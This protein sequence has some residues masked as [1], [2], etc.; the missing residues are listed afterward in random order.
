MLF[1]SGI[2]RERSYFVGNNPAIGIRVDRSQ[3]G[4]AID[5]QHTVET[6]SKKFEQ[7]LPLGT[8]VDLIRTRADY[9]AGRL[10]MLL[11]NGLTG[12][13]LVVLLLFLFLNART[14]FWVA[15]GIP[16]AMLAAITVMYFAGIT[17]NMISLFALIITLGIVVDD[18]I[19]VGEH[20][21][22]R[23]RMG[24]E[25]Y[26][27]AESA[28]KRMALPVFAATLTTIIAFFGLVVIGGRFGDLIADIPFTVVAVLAAS[29]VECFLILPNHM[30]H[31]LKHVGNNYWYDWPSRIVNFGFGWFREKIFGPFTR[32]VISSRYVV[33]AGAIAILASQVT[34]VISGKVN[35]RFF[36]APEQSSVTGNFAMVDTATREDTLAM[37]KTLQKTVEDLAKE[38][39]EKHGKNPVKYLLAEVGGNSGRGLSGTENKSKD[40]LGGIGIELIDADLRPYSSFAFVGELRDRVPRTALLEQISFRG[41]RAGPGGDALDIQLFGSSSKVLKEA[42]EDLKNE[43]SK[44]SQVSALED[45]LAYDKDDLILQLTP[46]GQAI[47]FTID[48]LGAILRSRLN[49]IEA[50][51]YPVGPRSA[52]ISVKL[53]EGELTSDFLDRMLL[54]APDGSY[55]PLADL[56]SVDR[57][58]GFSTVRR[59][60]GIRIV[61][62]TGDVSEDDPKAAQQV[63]ETLE[64]EIL[65]DLASK[66]QIEWQLAGL[67][68]QEDRFL[69]EARIGLITCLIGIYLVLTWV[70]ASWT[71]PIVVMAVIPFG[72]VGAIWGHYVWDVP[73]SMFSVV[74]L[75]GM[76]GIII[77]DSIVLITSIDEYARDRGI[78][79]SIVDA[80]KDRLRPVVLTTLTTVLGLAPLLYENSSQA[81]FLRPT[82][83]TLVYGLGFGMLLVLLVVPSLV[84]MQGD[85]KRFFVALRHGLKFRNLRIRLGFYTTAFFIV[86]WLS[87]TVGSQIL[88]GDSLVDFSQLGISNFNFGGIASAFLMYLLG[89]L[90]ILFI[91]YAVNAITS[92]KTSRQRG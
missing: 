37:M 72:L 91:F 13:G 14:A 45:N 34:M 68:E 60:N 29:L 26:E 7:T 75:L 73:L 52:S 27:A 66:Y 23:A 71:R 40:L 57:Q 32:L 20:A 87:A 10:K 77:N 43:L 39:E 67:S 5:I 17:I 74:G 22:H 16:T 63:M 21:D 65:P 1:R 85:L 83:I 70:F 38:Y 61:S 31:S 11:E 56:V 88:I 33:L 89:V 53:P 62:V 50:A 46:Q 47:G 76:T 9:I 28:A 92:V 41:W 30:A 4:D 44:Y 2:D 54:R 51:T 79:P 82:V 24:L 3:Q 58:A 80:V 12:L 78:V 64:S 59:E 90:A 18:A 19:V 8:T 36:N 55:V 49:G 69:N 42:S 15:A 81:Q 86:A 25:P 35:W 84:A 6:V 48:G